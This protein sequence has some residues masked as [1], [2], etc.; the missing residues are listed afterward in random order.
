MEKK[1][2]TFRLRLIYKLIISYAA[3]A[4]FT[5]AAVLYSLAGTYS[6]NT[7]A[8][9]L[10]R[11]DFAII[12]IIHKLSE[13]I[14]AQERNAGK[15]AILKRFEFKDLFERREQEFLKNLNELQKTGTELNLNSLI[16]SYQ[17]YRAEVEKIWTDDAEYSQSLKDAADGVIT[18]INTVYDD[19]QS[20]L[21]AK[22]EFANLKQ[23]ETIK[24]TLILSSTGI[25]LS[26]LIAVIF[27]YNISSAINKLKK[28]TLRIATG[29]FDY[30]P[31][32]PPGDEI[33]DL[34]GDFTRMAAKL[35][36]YEQVCLDA[37]PLTRL[38]GNIAIEDVINSRLKNGS[39][40]AVCY[41]D[42][43]NFKAYND[44]YGYI[45]ASDVIKMTAEVLYDSVSRHSD[46]NNF[47]GHIGGDDF[48]MIV[49]SDKVKP[50]CETAIKDFNER[51]RK[52]YSPDDAERG[53]IEGIDRYGVPRV[54]PI[55]TISIAVIM[56]QDGEYTS[57][58]D[59]GRAAADTKGNVKN[60]SGSN[61]MINYGK[62][63]G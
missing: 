22:I 30:D 35:K 43:D 9:D 48:I 11:N 33:G 23:T 2:V 25:I 19:H 56:C 63:I 13:S 32:I 31:S 7:T 45:K 40:F 10:A 4:I 42:L 28:A 47:V 29:D 59:I 16:E 6:I 21:A 62:N 24:W 53:S 49:P 57:A 26:I 8:R 55:M 50:V 52:Y 34:A 54:F 17:T 36:I 12:N 14:Q 37:S 61:Y 38:P 20:L 27:T 3:I 1:H 39:P 5:S 44:R 18:A 15:Y 51:I 46:V 60:R 58:V 41:A